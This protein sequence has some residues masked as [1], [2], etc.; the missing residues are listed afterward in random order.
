V[1]VVVRPANRRRRQLGLPQLRATNST[2]DDEDNPEL[3]PAGRRFL[4]STI[5]AGAIIEVLLTDV[6]SPSSTRP[7]GGSVKFSITTAAGNLV[8]A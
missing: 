4:Q 5:P 1:E 8:E 7:S 2:I 6:T 3:S